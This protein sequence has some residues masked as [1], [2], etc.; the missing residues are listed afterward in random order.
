MTPNFRVTSSGAIGILTHRYP[1]GCPAASQ[2]NLHPT[3]LTQ[4]PSKA[5][6]K[7]TQQSTLPKK[8]RQF[9]N[10]QES[11]KK[12]QTL[13]RC[14]EK[15]IQCYMSLAFKQQNKLTVKIG[16]SAFVSLRSE[17]SLTFF[18]RHSFTGFGNE[19][20]QF[21]SKISSSPR[22]HV[23]HSQPN[24]CQ[25]SS[26]SKATNEALGA[27]PNSFTNKAI[28]MGSWLLFFETWFPHPRNGIVTVPAL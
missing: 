7:C 10:S 3:H 4:A 8:D 24:I 25:H 17:L 23:S 26:V 6:P 21:F 9:P 1:C 11:F 15:Q 16:L 19:M 13:K 28:A 27:S 18:S 14:E 20:I 12:W 5:K 2:L 22:T